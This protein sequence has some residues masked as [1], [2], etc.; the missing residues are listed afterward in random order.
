MNRM[1]LYKNV[2]ISS[3]VYRYY[4]QLNSQ[5]ISYLQLNINDIQLCVCYQWEQ[6]YEVVGTKHQKV[7]H[8]HM[9]A[10]LCALH[11]KNL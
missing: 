10:S 11:N 2:D 8:E 6:S 3:C 4:L 7:M 9:V 5:L 1:T